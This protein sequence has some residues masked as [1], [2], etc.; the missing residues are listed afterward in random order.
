[1]HPSNIGDG[2]FRVAAMLLPLLALQPAYAQYSAHRNGDIVRLEDARHKTIV[3]II[4]SVGD[5]TFEMQVNGQNVL[6]SPYSSIEEFK[7][8]P[9][10]SGRKRSLFHRSMSIRTFPPID[11][12]EVALEI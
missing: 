9:R 1:M 8:H 12:I 7:A 5:V 2:A 11:S 6:Y 4:P 10:L 3:S